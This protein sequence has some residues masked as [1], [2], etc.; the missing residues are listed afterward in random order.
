MESNNV[1]MFKLL[2]GSNFSLNIFNR[3][4]STNSFLSYKFGCKL[5]RGGFIHTSFDNCKVTS[6]RN[7]NDNGQST[8][9]YKSKQSSS[10]K[11]SQSQVIFVTYSNKKKVTN[12]PNLLDL[13][14]S[15]IDKLIDYLKRPLRMSQ[16]LLLPLKQ[17]FNQNLRNKIE[18]Q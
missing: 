15:T 17:T 9:V 2:Q 3:N 1:G 6:S 16:V 18:T 14:S 13:A 7:K 11:C 12:R 4:T 10:P 5:V 8:E